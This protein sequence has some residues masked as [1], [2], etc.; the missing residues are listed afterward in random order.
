MA[1]KFEDCFRVLIDR[2]KT[3]IV[4]TSAGNTSEL[5]WEMSRESERVF[6]LDASMSLASLFGAGIALGNPDHTVIAFSGDGAF[7]MNPGMLFC[8]Y[9]LDLPNLKHFLV[10]NQVYG[11]TNDLSLP[12]GTFVDYAGLARASGIKRVYEFDEISAM[13]EKLDEIVKEPGHAFTVLHVEALG[14][15]SPSPPFDGAE[16]KFRFGRH[17]EARG[18]RPIFDEQL[19]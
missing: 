16:L 8:E 14:R 7:C 5:W 12:F 17:L 4:V 6:Y 2:F 19:K 18:C 10:S 13:S 1:M 11:S 9:Q 3:E 15:H